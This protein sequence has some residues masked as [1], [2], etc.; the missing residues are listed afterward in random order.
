MLK[1]EDR[2]SAPVQPFTVMREA[3]LQ[4]LLREG[5]PDV[6]KAAMTNVVVRTY[7]MNGDEMGQPSSVTE[8][9]AEMIY[10]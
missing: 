2:R 7:D 9:N 5:V 3:I 1:V 6:V 4:T 8:R 10:M